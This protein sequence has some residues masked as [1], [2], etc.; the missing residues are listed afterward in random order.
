[1][2]MLLVLP[3]N[4]LLLLSRSRCNLRGCGWCCCCHCG[5]RVAE[6]VVGG[7]AEYP[8]SAGGLRFE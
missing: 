8:A 3:S 1:M 5:Y 7:L 4:L 2:T 6:P